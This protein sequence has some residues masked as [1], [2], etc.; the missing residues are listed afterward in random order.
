MVTTHPTPDYESEATLG[1]SIYP[2]H[3]RIFRLTVR[4]RRRRRRLAFLLQYHTALPSAAVRF[5]IPS[6]ERARPH[7][8]S[9]VGC[10]IQNWCF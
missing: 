10:H 2:Y 1:D 7:F 3:Q 6:C 4:R 9:Y 8:A 5:T